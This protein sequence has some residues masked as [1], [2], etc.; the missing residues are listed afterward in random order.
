MLAFGLVESKC[1]DDAVE[2]LF[3]EYSA[4]ASKFRR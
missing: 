2:D 3:R 1:P 4:A